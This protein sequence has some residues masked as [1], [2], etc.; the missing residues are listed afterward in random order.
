MTIW[1]YITRFTYCLSSEEMQK[2]ITSLNKPNKHP[3]WA[4]LE[5]ALWTLVKVPKEKERFDFKSPYGI[6]VISTQECLKNMTIEIS[7]D[8]RKKFVSEQLMTRIGSEYIRFRYDADE[9]GILGNIS[10]LFSD[11]TDTL[12]NYVDDNNMTIY[13]LSL[14]SRFI[15]NVEL[16]KSHPVI[17]EP[18]SENIFL[19][20]GHRGPIM[21]SVRKKLDTWRMMEVKAGDNFRGID[22]YVFI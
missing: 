17:C 22:A 4:A 7:S 19:I 20:H 21:I 5:E 1:N 3:F 12:F 16:E 13:P 14:I 8:L 9:L 2:A 15:S 18:N 10:Q 6:P 11:Q